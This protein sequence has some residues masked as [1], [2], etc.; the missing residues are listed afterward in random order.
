MHNFKGGRE[1]VTLSCL[2]ATEG[3]RA[4]KD[5]IREFK[6]AGI[7]CWT[8]GA[9]TPYMGHYAINIW[10]KDEKRAIKILGW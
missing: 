2:K 5:V 6:E 7:E 10:K 1:F 4:K 3:G 8:Y 9:Y